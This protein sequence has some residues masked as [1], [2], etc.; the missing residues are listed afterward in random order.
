MM[1][2]G[3]LRLSDASA[4]LLALNRALD[5]PHP[6]RARVEAMLVALRDLMSRDADVEVMLYGDLE[7]DPC[8]K[9]LDRVWAGPTLQ[10]IEPRDDEAMQ[11]AVDLCEKAWRDIHAALKRHPWAVAVWSEDW[12]E[13][14]ASTFHPRHLQRHGWA[15][16]ATGV[17][18]AGNDRMVTLHVFRTPTQP[19]FS[20]ADRRLVMLMVQALAPLI[21][22]ELF[23]L[24]RY[25]V[26]RLSK[27]QQDVLAHLLRGLS[28][29]EIARKLHRS[30]ETI[31]NHVRAIYRQYDVNSR[32]ELM[33]RFIDQTRHGGA[34]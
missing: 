33:A 6:G 10:R 21:H 16:I 24:D 18:L 11:Q 26:D 17:W 34:A 14:F 32:G 20:E 25:G 27:R 28:E 12:P 15:D 4:V 1:D 22:R 7:R 2:G 9:L 19:P 3:F 13:W 29:K 23:T 31:H 5:T 30:V 8:P